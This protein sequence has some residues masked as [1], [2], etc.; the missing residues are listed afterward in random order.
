MSNL[1]IV[2]FVL[3]GLLLFVVWCR[4][5]PKPDIDRPHLVTTPGSRG[6]FTLRSVRNA[7]VAMFMV[8]VI[9]SVYVDP[10]DGGNNSRESMVGASLTWLVI[11]S[12]MRILRMDEQRYPLQW[13]DRVVTPNLW[14]VLERWGE[15]IT[16]TI[17]MAHAL[18]VFF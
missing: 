16:L 17:V 6:G 8:A 5:I 12:S 10:S 4:A 7:L 15:R 3:L 13:G 18:G 9:L 1:L 14:R 2:L 11:V